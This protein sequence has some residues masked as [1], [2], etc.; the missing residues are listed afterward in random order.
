MKV[1][2]PG[3][4]NGEE[5]DGSAQTLGIGGDG[6]QRFRCRAEQDAVDLARIHREGARPPIC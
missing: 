2:S 1:L 4:E 6:Q 3:V 5:S